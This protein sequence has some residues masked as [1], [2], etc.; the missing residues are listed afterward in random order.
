MLKKKAVYLKF[1]SWGYL[2]ELCLYIQLFWEQWLATIPQNVQF[3]YFFL[4]PQL[5]FLVEE[6]SRTL[7]T[8]FF[9]RSACKKFGLLTWSLLW[10]ISSSMKAG[11]TQSVTSSSGKWRTLGKN[12]TFKKLG[13][14]NKFTSLVE[15]EKGAYMAKLSGKI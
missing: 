2:T 6:K 3:I 9:A 14:N 4:F 13:H 8:K 1:L 10:K 7:K 5:L 11:R 12:L 15:V